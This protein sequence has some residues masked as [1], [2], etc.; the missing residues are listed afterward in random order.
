VLNNA[1]DGKP[2]VQAGGRDGAYISS[3]DNVKQQLETISARLNDVA[4]AANRYSKGLA[5][6]PC[7][8]MLVKLAIEGRELFGALVVDYIDVS[9]AARTLRDS[10]YLQIVATK[11][12]AVIPLE[13]VYE[14]KSPAADAKVCPNAQKALLDGKCPA[15]C[16]PKD[17]PA[18]HVCPM[19]FWGLR[20]VIERHVHNPALGQ[21][22]YVEAVE[23]IAGRDVIALKGAALLAASENVPPKARKNLEA[24]VVKGWKTAG[25]VNPV[26]K[27]A[28]WKT[29]VNAKRPTLLVALPHS[30]GANAGISLEISGDTLESRLIDED[31]LRPAKDRPPPLVLLMGCRR[32]RCR[33]TPGPYTSHVAQFPA[34][35]S[36]P[37]ILG[38]LAV[39]E[40]GDATRPRRE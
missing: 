20:K 36:A 9:A 18:S 17:S 6:K 16:V 5:S 27:W 4:R 31:Y 25:T 40:G 12:D 15:D 23:A 38:T 26:E 7:A 32:G 29:T 2:T 19:G 37:V 10:E 3:L 13:L 11:P 33:A 30:S 1:V 24:S 14:Y 39:I 21:E 28:Q 8:E 34:R 35:R 22:G